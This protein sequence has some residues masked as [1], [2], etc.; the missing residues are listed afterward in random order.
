MIRIAQAQ[1]SADYNQLEAIRCFV[2][3]HA[4]ALGIASQIVCDFTWCVTEIV[5]NVIEHGYQE[6][7]GLV[8][9][10]LARQERDFM[11]QISDQAP[12][13]D[14]NTSPEPDLTLPLEQRTPGGLGVYM[15][16]KMMDVLAY[17]LTGNG[18]NQTTLVK[19]NVI[20]AKEDYYGTIA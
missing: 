15:T 18:Y 19:W 7:S 8:E 11:I 14:P 10:V 1:F 5:T 9:I 17:Q 12:P 20:H 16:K 6:K 13:F 4:C 3:E 2:E